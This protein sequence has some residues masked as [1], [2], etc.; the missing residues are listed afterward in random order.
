M[1]AEE[2]V[3]HIAAARAAGDADQE[4]LAQAILAYKEEGRIRTWARRFAPTAPDWA[5]EE[6]AGEAFEDAM[7]GEWQGE[8]IGSFRAYAK[9]ITHRRAA[10]F[11][12]TQKGDAALKQ[13]SLEGPEGQDLLERMTTEDDDLAEALDLSLRVDGAR[14]VLERLRERRPD[15]AAIV[16]GREWQ[17]RSSAD[18]AEEHGTTGANVDQ[19]VRRYRVEVRRFFEEEA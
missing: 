17:D 15:H 2:I 4:A 9:Q 13:R 18:V 8:R 3:A 1:P 11:Q 7:A 10:D 6:I 12:R 5:I 14:I 19:I 16:E